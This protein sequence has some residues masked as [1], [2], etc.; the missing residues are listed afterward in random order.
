VG[1]KT[2]I[3][4]ARHGF[5]ASP[6][7]KDVLLAPKVE[8]LQTYDAGYLELTATGVAYLAGSRSS[9]GEAFVKGASE[10]GQS[11]YGVGELVAGGLQNLYDRRQTK[12]VPTGLPA[13]VQ[14]ALKRRKSLVAG[15]GDIVSVRYKSLGKWSQIVLLEVADSSGSG[16]AKIDLRNRKAEEIATT[17]AVRRVLVEGTWIMQEAVTGLRSEPAI[18]RP[19]AE[20][21]AETDDVLKTLQQLIDSAG[22]TRKQVAE[23]ALQQYPQ[24]AEFES[25]P[26]VAE[27]YSALIKG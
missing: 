18:P 17:I 5:F 19:F 21:I 22:L 7:T 9:V 16:S 8:R 6:S 15:Y 27:A 10:S 26:A 23:R 14:V 11:V 12:D 20:K 1:I 3:S 25:V 2:T 13:D 4:V 24:F